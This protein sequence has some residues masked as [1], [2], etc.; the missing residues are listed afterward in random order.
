MFKLSVLAGGL[1]L[2]SAIVAPAQ[3]PVTTTTT[4]APVGVAAPERCGSAS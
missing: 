3:V 4:E 1:V 2:T